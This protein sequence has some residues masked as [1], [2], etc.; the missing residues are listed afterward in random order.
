MPEL[1]WAKRTYDELVTG[2]R[3]EGEALVFE[4]GYW[5][6][7]LGDYLEEGFAQDVQFHVLWNDWYHEPTFAEAYSS[8]ID[9]RAEHTAE[10][11]YVWAHDWMAGRTWPG[12][13][14]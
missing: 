11:L 6:G 14:A 2:G 1:T 8:G 5:L 12:R 3:F 7:I 9:D 4:R 10:D 13:R